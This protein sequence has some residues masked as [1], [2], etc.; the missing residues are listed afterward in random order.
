MRSAE[1]SEPSGNLIRL[2]TRTTS[3]LK[4]IHT[5]AEN[6][7]RFVPLTFEEL[8]NFFVEIGPLLLL[9]RSPCHSNLRLRI[10]R[11]MVSTSPLACTRKGTSH[12][13]REDLETRNR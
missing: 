1:N 9:E 12:G 4:S 6:R 2:E 8:C 11:L 7:V 13:L 10:G 5:E 3:N